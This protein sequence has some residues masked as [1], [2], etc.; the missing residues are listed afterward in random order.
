MQYILRQTGEASSQNRRL[1]EAKSPKPQRRRT[2]IKKSM[3]FSGG[4]Q[5]ASPSRSPKLV[6]ANDSIAEEERLSDSPN[7]VRL[8]S[9]I[10]HKVRTAGPCSRGEIGN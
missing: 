7:Y 2:A 4:A 3:S 8:Y 1:S 6:A 10:T 9:V 5:S